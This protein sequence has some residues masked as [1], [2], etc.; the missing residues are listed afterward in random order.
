MEKHAAYFKLFIQSYISFLNIKN[1]TKIYKLWNN[2]TFLLKELKSMC[3]QKY[4]VVV[5][6]NTILTIHK[7]KKEY[8]IKFLNTY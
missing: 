5:V 8:K 7:G 4:K 1:L 3:N 6:T 2:Q